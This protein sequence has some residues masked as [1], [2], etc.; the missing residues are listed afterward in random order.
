[1]TRACTIIR[2]VTAGTAFALPT[3]ADPPMSPPAPDGAD[4]VPTARCLQSIVAVPYLCLRQQ[5]DSHRIQYLR[6]RR[7]GAP[8]RG[9]TPRDVSDGALSG[10]KSG[11]CDENP[12]L[13]I[14]NRQILSCLV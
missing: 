4:G 10:D 9:G 6:P 13:H 2:C 3:A 5:S 14:R 12:G 8:R 7:L 11:L 1:M